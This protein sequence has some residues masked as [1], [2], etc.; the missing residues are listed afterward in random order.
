[1]RAHGTQFHPVTGVVPC[2]LIIPDP[3]SLVPH[4]LA[5][6]TLVAMRNA[7]VVWTIIVSSIRCSTPLAA[8]LFLSF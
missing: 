1:M 4:F 2:I 3:V 5:S 7:P 6:G 8:R